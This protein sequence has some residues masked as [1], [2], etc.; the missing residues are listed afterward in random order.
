MA[1]AAYYRM[2]AARRSIAGVVFVMVIEVKA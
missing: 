1:A 2:V